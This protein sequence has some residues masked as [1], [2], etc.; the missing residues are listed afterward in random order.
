MLVDLPSNSVS[1]T[2][3]ADRSAQIT[4]LLRAIDLNPKNYTCQVR[5]I[6]TARIDQSGFDLTAFLTD[7]ANVSQLK[8]DIS[9]GMVSL[10]G[11][12]QAVEAGL[13][14]LSRDSSYRVDARPQLYLTEAEKTIFESVQRVPLPSVSQTNSGTQSGIVFE[15]VGFSLE[16]T[17]LTLHDGRVSLLLSQTSG[18]IGEVREVG[19]SEVPIIERQRISSRTVIKPSQWYVLG[20]LRISR[21]TGKTSF[22]SKANETEN[23]DL[24][25]MIS[26][27]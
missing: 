21:E 24:V 20:G 17:P 11:T 4:D 7:M 9:Q 1:W 3:P 12:S 27:E 18:R 2:L 13:M 10:V 14:I 26:I 8:L 15:D 16:L 19:G 5:I 22:F 6:S 23:A 25:I